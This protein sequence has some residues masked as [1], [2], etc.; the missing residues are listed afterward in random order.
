[1]PNRCLHIVV[2]SD[3]EFA[4]EIFWAK[5]GEQDDI[6]IHAAQENTDHKA[7]LVALTKSV[8]GREKIS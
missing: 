2:I 1:M 5:E 7:V 6:A 8:S 3:A 4:A